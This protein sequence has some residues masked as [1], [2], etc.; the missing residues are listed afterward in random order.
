MLPPNHV[1]NL[2]PTGVMKYE[3]V[4]HPINLTEQNFRFRGIA[5]I[6]PHLKLMRQ[7]VYVSILLF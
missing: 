5:H 2:A 1:R 3:Q 4:G 7:I 6:S